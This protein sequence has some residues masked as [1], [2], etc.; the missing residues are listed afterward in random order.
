ML[1]QTKH[2]QNEKENDTTDG[3]MLRRIEWQLYSNSWVT[4]S[5]KKNT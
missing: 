5:H 1:R 3:K 2:S 4:K